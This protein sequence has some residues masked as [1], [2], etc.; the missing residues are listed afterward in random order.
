MTDWALVAVAYV[1][2]YL[3]LHAYCAKDLK[4]KA[5]FRSIAKEGVF[6]ENVIKHGLDELMRIVWLPVWLLAEALH[7]I[8]VI[9]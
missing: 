1:G 6:S 8:G 7:A 2:A 4:P 9:E 3:A 5:S